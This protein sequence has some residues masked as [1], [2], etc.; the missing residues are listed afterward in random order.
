MIRKCSLGKARASHAKGGE[1]SFTRGGTTGFS[2]MELLIVIAIIGVLA[3]MVLSFGSYMIT[4]SKWLVTIQRIDGAIESIQRNKSSSSIEALFLDGLGL[5][6][7]FRPLRS[8]IADLQDSG[9][10]GSTA[11]TCL[12]GAT[13]T[14]PQNCLPPWVLVSSVSKSEINRRFSSYGWGTNQ[15]QNIESIDDVADISPSREIMTIK[16]RPS[17]YWYYAAWPVSWPLPTWDQPI[18]PTVTPHV[19]SVCVFPTPM[20]SVG[21]STTQYEPVPPGLTIGNSPFARS[22]IRPYPLYT[23]KEEHDITVIKAKA[24]LAGYESIRSI[25]DL[26]APAAN[27]LGLFSPLLTTRLFMYAGSLSGSTGLADYR[28][29]RKPERLWNDRWGNPLVLSSYVFVPPRHLAQIATFPL[30]SGVYDPYLNASGTYPAAG[31]A[32]GGTWFQKT[33]MRRRDYLLQ[34]YRKMLGYDRSI[35]LSGGAVGPTRKW[36][37]LKPDGSPEPTDPAIPGFNGNAP[38]TWTAE[39]AGVDADIGVNSTIAPQIPVPLTDR[40]IL[41]GLWAQVTTATQA[42]R[43]DQNSGSTPPWKGSSLRQTATI[44]GVSV[45]CLITNPV[46]VK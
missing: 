15:V 13:S 41:R 3:G 39:T 38:L 2:L 17:A 33:A 25:G 42:Q 40:K 18:P 44:G 46:E 29:D 21:Q 16:R 11:G 19:G 24:T 36:A 27:H 14:N 5:D 1:K 34:A 4:Q 7:R 8:I 37:K 22:Q 28:G 43:W 20:T 32:T 35:F 30:P 10:F 45:E 9:M 12:L 6:M 26:E 23:G 31:D